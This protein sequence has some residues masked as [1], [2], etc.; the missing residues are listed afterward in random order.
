MSLLVQD[1]LGQSHQVQQVSHPQV[2]PYQP[3]PLRHSTWKSWNWLLWRYWNFDLQANRYQTAQHLGCMGWVFMPYLVMYNTFWGST[4]WIHSTVYHHMSVKHHS[5]WHYREFLQC[6]LYGRFLDGGGVD[7][8]LFGPSTTAP[9]ENKFQKIIP[10]ET[11][12]VCSRPT[13]KTNWQ[14]QPKVTTTWALVHGV[15]SGIN[16]TERFINNQL[17]N[18]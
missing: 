4:V 5:F 13:Q 17:F 10:I 18:K 15:T 2:N 14:T 8:R 11:Q 7:Q 16:T 12:G 1:H 3:A 6:S 9:L